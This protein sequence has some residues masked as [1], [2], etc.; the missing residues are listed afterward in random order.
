MTP[1]EREVLERVENEIRRCHRCSLGGLRDSAGYM[2]VPG[3]GDP[4]S[5]VMFIGEAPGEEE[6]LQGRPFVGRAGKLLTELL[7]SINLPREKV[8]IANILKCRPPNNRDPEEGEVEACIG[9]LHAQISLL[10]PRVICLLGNIAIHHLLGPR[11]SLSEHKGKLLQRGGIFFLPC[12]HPAA[13]LRNP[14]LRTNLLMDFQRLKNLLLQ[15]APELFGNS[16]SS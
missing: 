16:S 2:A 6:A 10:R 15:V 11:Y 12:Y 13:V 14:R 7:N 8:Y 1:E 3:E 9:Y 5:P 4:A